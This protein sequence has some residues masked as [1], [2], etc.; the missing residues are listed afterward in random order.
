MLCF[1]HEEYRAPRFQLGTVKCLLVLELELA[2]VLAL[3]LAL[4]LV[5]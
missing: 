1:S 3:M 2:L 4:V 5:A